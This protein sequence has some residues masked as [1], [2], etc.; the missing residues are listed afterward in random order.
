M[1]FLPSEKTILARV[2]AAQMGR[3][4]GAE[5]GVEVVAERDRVHR[6]QPQVGNDV[7]SAA[8]RVDVLD[9]L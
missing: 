7:M 6:E 4:G 3:V 8:L 1:G 9:A 2:S 5:L